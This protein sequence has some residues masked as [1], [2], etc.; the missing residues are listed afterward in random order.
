MSLTHL[1]PTAT[2]LQVLDLLRADGACIIDELA[3]PGLMNQVAAEME[4]H[5]RIAPEPQGGDPAESRIRRTGALIAR[6]PAIRKLVTDPLILETAEGLLNKASSYQV[7]V[8]QVI[9]VFPGGVDQRLHRDQEAWD[10]FPF[11]TDYDMQCNTMWAL[12]DFS[13]E[14][15]ATRIVRGTHLLPPNATP[16]EATA[17]RV[18]EQAA[19][20]QGSVLVFTGKVFHG[21]A[22]N[23]TDKVRHGIDIDYCVG[24]VRQ[25]ENQYLATPIEVAKTLDEALLRLMGYQLGTGT[26]GYFRDCED[27]LLALFDHPSVV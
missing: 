8:T 25:E 23:K 24:W 5:I 10:S 27:P 1:P 3:S 12:T 15:G 14:N 4:P 17:G 13:A 18:V 2:S 21:A 9:S 6:S 11:P 26:L 22:A 20:K 16:D 7:H 19:M